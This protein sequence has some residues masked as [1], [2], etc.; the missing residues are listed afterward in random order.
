MKKFIMVAVFAMMVVNMFGQTSFNV[1]GDVQISSNNISLGTGIEFE[2]AHAFIGHMNAGVQYKDFGLSVSY[3]GY[4][5]LTGSET[6]FNLVDLIGSYKVNSELTIMAGY[7]LTYWDHKIEDDEIGDGIFAM[8]TW[9][10]GKFSTTGIIFTNPQFSFIYLI[11]SANYQITDH[12]SAYGLVAYTNAEAYPF[13]GLAGLKV[14]KGSI[15]V[16]AYGIAR[17]NSP[18]V[19]INLEIGF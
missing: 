17:Y 18:G 15:S 8:A 14:S 3:G 11:E 12:V 4:K 7:E 9:S 19:T 6:M 16:G 10:K 2:K 5:S 1:S 13:Y